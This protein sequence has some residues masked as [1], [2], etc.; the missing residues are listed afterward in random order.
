MHPAWTRV[1]ALAGVLALL[2]LSTA[3]G[4]PS[5]DLQKNLKVT[6]I[7]TGWYDTGIVD[8]K[9]KLVPSIAFKLHNAAS[10]PLVSLQVNCVFRRVGET[11]EWGTAYHGVT[12]SQGLA[13]DATSA[14]LTLRSPLG[15]TG[16]EPPATMLQNHLFVDAQVTV[17]GKYGSSQWTKV[18]E[19]PIKRVLLNP[20]ASK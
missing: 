19:I 6:D 15:Y 20:E 8:G 7:T 18:A 16:T 2:A 1:R 13:P 4:G 5:I 3:C 17:F 11:D 12:G 9:H 14:E 10:D